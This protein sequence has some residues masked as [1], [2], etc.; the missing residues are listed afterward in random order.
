MGTWW[1]N[2]N[3]IVIRYEKIISNVVTVRPAPSFNQ[4]VDKILCLNEEYKLEVNTDL[5]CRLLIMLAD[6]LLY[7]EMSKKSKV[8]EE[9]AV[10]S[11]Q[12]SYRKER[13]ESITT[14]KTMD[15]LDQKINVRRDSLRKAAKKK[16]VE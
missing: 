13:R 11:H 14:A 3:S 8:G 10:H 6:W 15:Y 5:P 12:R 1:L 7:E 2:E 16:K 9:Y 4:R